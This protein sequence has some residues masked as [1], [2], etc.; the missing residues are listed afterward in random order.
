MSSKLY[1]KLGTMAAGKSLELLKTADTYERSG[2]RVLIFTPNI[3]N[4]Y[5]KD[6]VVSRTGLGHEATS[7][8]IDDAEQ[9][10]RSAVFERPDVILIDECQFFTKRVIETLAVAIVDGL[11]IPVICYGLKTNFKGELFEGS[12]ELFALA[13]DISEIKGLCQCCD[14]KATMNLRFVDGN[15]AKEGDEVLIGDEEYRSVCR[16]HF[17]NWEEF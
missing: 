2:R 4:R 7:V 1:A 11:N 10:Y 16:K 9:I 14:R 13:D 12:A 5:G 8:H 17:Y 6:R 3:D 15:P